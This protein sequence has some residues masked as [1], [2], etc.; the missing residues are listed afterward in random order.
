MKTKHYALLAVLALSTLALP[1][2]APAQPLPLPPEGVLVIDTSK[3][4]LPAKAVYRVETE[5]EWRAA[6]EK[7]AGRITGRVHFL[8][9]FPERVVLSLAGEGT[10]VSVAGSN[11]EGWS[12][13]RESNNTRF[14]ELIPA[15]PAPGKKIG[16]LEFD[17]VLEGPAPQSGATLQPALPGIG[18][19][20]GFSGSVAAISGAGW[21]W[22]VLEKTGLDPSGELAFFS[23]PAPV[24]KLRAHPTG[25][26][27]PPAELDS[28]GLEGVWNPETRTVAFVLRTRAVAR[29]AGARIPFLRGSIA[30]RDI[31]NTGT[32]MLVPVPGGIDLVASAPGTQELEFRAVASARTLDGWQRLD[33]SI[34]AATL[35]GIT[36]S[37]LPTPVDFP[38][39]SGV[40]LSKRE[41]GAAV[42]WLPPS[43]VC[44]AGWREATGVASTAETLFFNATQRSDVRVGP[45]TVA[46]ES[47]IAVRVLQGKMESL[48]LWFDGTGDVLDASGTNSAG[49]NLGEVDGRGLLRI[50]L[51]RPVT[52][53]AEFRVRSRQAVGEFPAEI[54]PQRFTPRDPGARTSG[55]IR[56]ST[57]GAV[58]F[59][60]AKSDGLVQVAAKL[61]GEKA[62]ADAGRVYQFFSGDFSLGLVASQVF[63]EVAVN[64]VTLYE[65]TPSDRVI[66]ARIELDIREAPLRD[67]EIRIPSGYAVASLYGT[68]VSDY[69][70]GSESDGTR[71]VR[72]L[73]GNPVQG[74]ATLD[75]RLETNTRAAAGQWKLPSL[76]FPSAKS[77]R[78][79]VGVA[80]APGFRL[81]T[82]SIKGLAETP[83]GFFPGTPRGLQLAFRQREPDWSATVGIEALGQSIA[84]D[85]FH[86]YSLRENSVS[87]SVILNF[88]VVGSPVNE[89]RLRV[90]KDA[91][92]L[93]IDGQDVR[94][95]RREGDEI[96]VSL[97]RPALGAATLLATFEHPLAG[98][99][100]GLGRIEPVGVSSERGF[101]QIVSPLQVKS[102]FEASD[103]LLTI[104][105]SEL[106][107]E[108]RLL[109]TAPSLGVFSYSSR[110][111]SL[112]LSATPFARADTVE[113]LVDFARLQTRV[114]GDG[115]IMTDATYLV[116]TRGAG[117]LAITL[118]PDARLWEA[119]VNGGLTTA[120][121]ENEKTLIPLPASA[122]P[123]FASE[124]S[125]RYGSRAW[126]A[127]RTSLAAPTV[128]APV[129]ATEWSVEPDP[130]HILVAGS[131]SS[132]A[133]SR[134][135]PRTG[136]EW[137][138]GSPGWAWTM[139]A[140]WLAGLFVMRGAGGKSSRWVAIA[141]G[142]ALA[143]IA[144]AGFFSAFTESGVARSTL[145]LAV[146][147]SG[148]GQPVA[149]TVWNLPQNLAGVSITG[150]AL[151]LLGLF[152]FALARVLWRRRNPAWIAWFV[153][154][155]GLLAQPRGGALFFAWAAVSAA[156]VLLPKVRAGRAA[157]FITALVLSVIQ[158]SAPAA[159]L[160]A[161]SI[162]SLEESAVIREGAS[163]FEAR[164][165]FETKEPAGGALLLLGS[166]GTLVSFSGEGL[167]LRKIDGAFHVAATRAGRFTGTLRYSLATPAIGDELLLPTGPAASRSLKVSID[168][169]G[170]SFSSPSAIEVATP[171]DLPAN[172]SGARIQFAP[173]DKT[174]LK[175]HPVRRD[176]SR[177]ALGFFASS[178]Q[179]FVP[180]PGV[181]HARVELR[182]NVSRGE[183]RELH[184]RV[185]EGFLIESISGKM[186]PNAPEWNF[187]PATRGARI[188]LP[189]AMRGDFAMN[190]ALQMPSGNLPAEHEFTPL[191]VPGAE[192]QSGLL[193][194]AFPGDA[195]PA[196][197]KPDGLAL[198]NFEDFPP[199]PAIGDMAPALHRVFRY[200]GDKAKIGLRVLPVEPEI[201]SNIAQTVSLGS[202]RCV[203]S[204]VIVADIRRA[205]VFR[206]SF[207][208]PEGWEIE[209][210]S[211]EDLA[212]WLE[213][214]EGASRRVV[215]ALKERTVG[216]HTFTVS[217]SAPGVS[218]AK[219]WEVPRIAL[220]GA[221][222]A[223]GTLILVPERGLRLQPATRT[224]CSPADPRESGEIQPGSLAFRLL[225]RDWKLTLGIE[226][227]DPWLTAQSLENVELREGQILR[228]AEIRFRVEHAAIK[229]VRVSIPGLDEEARK[230][231]R[232]E[233]EALADF[234]PVDADTWEV[235]FR[236]GVPGEIPVRVELQQRTT[237][238]GGSF[239]FRP[240]VPVAAR[241]VAGFAALRASGRLEIDL[242]DLP[243][244][245]ERVDWNTVPDS[246]RDNAPA[247]AVTLRQPAS[248][249]A[250][251]VGFRRQEIAD[252]LKLRVSSGALDTLFS[253]RGDSATTARFEVRVNEKSTMRLGLVPGANLVRIAVNGEEQAVVRDGAEYLFYVL[254]P[255]EAD[256]PATV[257]FAY[258]VPGGRRAGTG[259]SLA[260]PALNAPLEN[261]TWSVRLPS[262]FALRSASGDFEM[263]EALPAARFG[264]DEYRALSSSLRSERARDAAE[265]MNRAGEY[266]RAGEQTQARAALNRAAKT[267]GLD[268]AANED[269]RVQLQNL[270]S[271]QAVLGL[272]TRRQK[273]YL[274][275][276][277]PDEAL[278]DAPLARAARS[279]PLLQGQADI[280]P[281]Q[282][283]QILQGNSLEEAGA[284]RRLA[285]RIVS[286][287]LAAEPAPR[288]VTPTLPQPGSAVV[289]AR[290]LQVD[291]A[292]P[293]QL[294]IE[295]E[296][297]ASVSIFFIL[298]F[299][300]LLAICAWAAR[301]GRPAKN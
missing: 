241:Q 164:F 278:A 229:S 152:L 93:A 58:R 165:T 20:S 222:R 213:T 9:S 210:A 27:A 63:P 2:S 251:T 52:G 137:L 90:P 75:L 209:T 135:T 188:A 151:V 131:S 103:A 33:F 293:L 13:R 77:T 297:T 160:P 1:A 232:F 282:M 92:N 162:V 226:P 122:D 12:V 202:E 281:A 184:V 212:H 46:Y 243:R 230:T 197:V 265:L 300:A 141:Q 191:L 218:S 36:L 190:L 239:A 260:A 45:G 130:G 114:S 140:V 285:E 21:S 111:F 264:L 50:N 132:L 35:A 196:D 176:P 134:T 16:P 185:P 166:A 44:N 279:N 158:T 157:L 41:D 274:D 70:A 51:S 244:G 30:L 189:S 255:A 54:E 159:A 119:K 268:E 207:P 142:I 273:L 284:L 5:T 169:P 147:I 17:V 200:A 261:L 266:L 227:G 110:P 263:R 15:K 288:A 34:P 224:N 88:F 254:P 252:S 257:E 94:S 125:L 64:Q 108:L 74:R 37:G 99:P 174:V 228:S 55:L 276:A 292:R 168:E 175:I 231:V 101:I 24:L 283:E 205:P 193:A 136:F 286:Q 109:T 40:M 247:P 291:G 143:A 95:W 267:A 146:P 42:G 225:Q 154:S 78:G 182:I 249:D 10:V 49:W 156:F 238:V 246:L 216:E 7:T 271:Q 199:L 116:K 71:S 294:G 298:S 100:L 6:K 280:A 277:L 233:S 208:L 113:Q 173:A 67:L 178:N 270:A 53:V 187:D 112:A 217:L 105:P 240:I 4:P 245:W 287:Q 235:T 62:D 144:L 290:G 171:A 82:E 80:T 129:F 86:L 126:F 26:L 172:T 106:P 167:T 198:V 76:A 128:D 19:A 295:I 117:A 250:L 150:L 104:E 253:T 289:F 195:Q 72:V 192:S 180:A 262:G 79:F 211:G 3:V 206:L 145:S 124:V 219:D 69:Q 155:I 102:A 39:D 256:K 259:I 242:P 181:V 186:F 214:G 120:R 139:G 85:L 47:T 57:A 66:Q 107:A 299:V 133:A 220:D 68:E 258:Q 234:A 138:S 161:A 123:D 301:G 65:I 153:I 14:L 177:E 204:A 248:G 38:R 236:R 170:W 91:E 43:G 269:A 148:A 183:M 22:E 59:D 215:L 60:V 275:N 98:S 97:E 296:R 8:E 61:W 221:T 272:N 84:S 194:L 96:I 179:I 28:V 87:G 81:A 83:T 201:R 56:L 25:S 163:E 73:F 31:P 29:E 121:V 237:A 115:Q 203:L 32:W 118:P 23:G 89:W 11:V 223:G 48:E 18:E 127:W 149:V